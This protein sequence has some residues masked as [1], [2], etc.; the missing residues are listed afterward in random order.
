MGIVLGLLGLGMGFAQVYHWEVLEAVRPIGTATSAQAWL[1]AVEG[2]TMAIGIAI[3]GYVVENI[4]PQLALGGVSVGLIAS[5][6]YV[7]WYAVPR[8]PE[9]NKP[10]SETQKIEVLADLESPAE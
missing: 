7:W 6:I 5:T 2:S 8:L 9:A 10:L 4:S 3:G 1:W